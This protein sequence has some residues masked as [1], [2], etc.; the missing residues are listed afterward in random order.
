MKAMTIHLTESQTAKLEVVGRRSG[1]SPDALVQRA[2]DM[3]IEDV[4]VPSST[5]APIDEIQ[6]DELTTSSSI[7][8]PDL[9]FIGI[10][11]SRKANPTH[12]DRATLRNEIARAVWEDSFGGTRPWSESD[13]ACLDKPHDQSS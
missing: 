8:R 6:P 10:G 1:I 2:I 3:L 12:T 9:W 13:E 4:D 5:T 7:E 11:S